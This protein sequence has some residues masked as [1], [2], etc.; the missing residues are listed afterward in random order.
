MGADDVKRRHAESAA[1]ARAAP[2]E[3]GEGKVPRIARRV[4]GHQAVREV[5]NDHFVHVCGRFEQRQG[6]KQRE[7]LRAFRFRRAFQFGD[8]RE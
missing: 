3:G 2:G 7:A 1:P 8:Y 5:G 4:A 6:V